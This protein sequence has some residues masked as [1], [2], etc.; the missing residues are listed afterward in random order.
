MYEMITMRCNGGL[1]DGGWLPA[2]PVSNGLK[3][4]FFSPV[5]YSPDQGEGLEME[6]ILDH[7]DMMKPP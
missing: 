1:L 5:P 4:G 3:L 2:R 7:A 6:L